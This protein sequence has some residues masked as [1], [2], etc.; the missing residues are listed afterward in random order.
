MLYGYIIS[1]I[2]NA[3]IGSLLYFTLNIES[4]YNR[5]PIVFFRKLPTDEKGGQT[6][7]IF[8]FWYKYIYIVYS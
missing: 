2:S 6:Y 8:V 3:K 4:L 1:N 7:P 5:I